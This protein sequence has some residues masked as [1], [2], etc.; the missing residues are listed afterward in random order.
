MALQ[1]WL[2]LTTDLRNQGLTNTTI[3]NSGATFI[4][5]GGKLGGCYS[6][7][8]T[9]DRLSYTPSVDSLEEFSVAL[10]LCP[11][12][13]TPSGAFFSIERDTYWQVTFWNDKIGI[14]DNS[15]GYNGTRKDFSTGTYTAN[16]WTH[17]AIT[18]NKGALKIYRDGILLSTNA[19]GGTKLN[20]GI[21]QGRIGSAAQAGYFHSGK[22]SDVRFYD[23][24]LSDE[25]VKELSRGL[26]LYYHLDN[27]GT[28]M[29]YSEIGNLIPNS[30]TMA[31]GTASSTMGTWRLAGTSNMTQKRVLVQ[32]SPIG[33]CYAFQNEGIQTANDGSCYGIDSTTYFEPYSEYRISMFARIVSGSE[34]YAGYNI[35]NISEELGGSHTKI[36]KNYRVTPLNPDGSWT[37]CWYHIKTN[38]SATRNIYI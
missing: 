21:N 24:C 27:N 10:W 1:I 20:T 28:V 31:L 18:Y 38:S 14:R 2:P 17:I 22:I 30:K 6:F 3:T 37:Y 7:D 25:E 11:A 32:D 16:V 33:E 15:I 19:V 5:S 35:Y 29:N 34:G 36:E 8:G 13:A 9:D 26:V 23:N 4:S 12:A